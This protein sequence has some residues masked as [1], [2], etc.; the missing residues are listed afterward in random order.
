MI[1]FYL[2]TN[3]SEFYVKVCVCFLGFLSAT[4]RIFE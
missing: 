2:I 3:L 1:F 4:W